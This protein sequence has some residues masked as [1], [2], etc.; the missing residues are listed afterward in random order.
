MKQITRSFEDYLEEILIC[1][2]KY[3]FVKAVNLASSMGVSRPAVAKMLKALELEGFIIREKNCIILSKQ[4]RLVA[5]KVYQKHLTI[6][7][8]LL[9]I[10]VGKDNAEVDCCKIEHCISNETFN[11]IKKFMDKKGE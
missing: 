7:E 8:F 1:E 6:K 5:E 4:G 9:Q 10:G 11:A 3:K 2:K